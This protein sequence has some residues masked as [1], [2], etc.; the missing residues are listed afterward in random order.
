[1]RVIFHKKCPPLDQS[2][3]PVSVL[4]N[5]GFC[6]LKDNRVDIFDVRKADNFHGKKHTC[7]I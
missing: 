3:C 2:A 5:Q 7:G 1:M 4:Y 6:E